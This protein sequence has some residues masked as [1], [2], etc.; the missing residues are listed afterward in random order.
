MKAIKNV[1]QVVSTTQPSEPN[2]V[3][4]AEG[5]GTLAGRTVQKTETKNISLAKVAMVGAVLLTIGMAYKSCDG[6]NFGVGI[7]KG[8]SETGNGSQPLLGKVNL[9]GNNVAQI[10]GKHGIRHKPLNQNDAP[11]AARPL[12]NFSALLEPMISFVSSFFPKRDPNCYERVDNIILF[13]GYVFQGCLA[14]RNTYGHAIPGYGIGILNGDRYE[15]PWDHNLPHGKGRFTYADGATYVGEVSYGKRK[16]QG[17]YT[18][19]NGTNYTGS[20]DIDQ[21]NGFGIETSPDNCRFEGKFLNN[22]HYKGN[23]TCP[24]KNLSGTWNSE[25]FGGQFTGRETEKDIDGCVIETE[26]RSG[27]KTH[28]KNLCQYTGTNSYDYEV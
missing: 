17:N 4:R 9:T 25:S 20:W 16:G 2:N 10:G 1:N 27:R 18:K 26:F 19:S 5:K 11:M 24:N 28:R 8:A 14:S 3:Q 7:G 6:F 22:K 15:G 12:V 13:S 21:K 23:L